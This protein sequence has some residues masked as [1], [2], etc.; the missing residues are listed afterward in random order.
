MNTRRSLFYLN[1]PSA[2]F[3]TWLLWNIFLLALVTPISSPSH[4]NFLVSPQSIFF[5][6]SLSLCLVA[7]R[8]RLPP[9]LSALIVTLYLGNF[10]HFHYFNCNVYAIFVTPDKF[11]CKVVICIYP[12]TYWP[13]SFRYLM[14]IFPHVPFTTTKAPESTG[15][16]Q[17]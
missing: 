1:F 11:P 10:V 12:N 3:H 14:D 5:F 7:K 15:L 13:P 16:S 8:W 6:W 17:Q 2:A 9:L 4:R